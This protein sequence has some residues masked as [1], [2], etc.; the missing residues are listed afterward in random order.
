MENLDRGNL[1]GGGWHSGVSTHLPL[2]CLRSDSRPG[3]TCGLR[4]LLVLI[5]VLGV[6]DWVLQFSTIHKNQKSTSKQR[7]RRAASW[8]V[9]CEISSQ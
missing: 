2:L 3:V 6:F 5:L 4:L 1:G 8:N 7:T 9:H